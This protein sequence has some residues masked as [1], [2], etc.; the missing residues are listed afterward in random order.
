MIKIIFKK[1]ERLMLWCGI[2]NLNYID[3]KDSKK[4]VKKR[5]KE[6]E[7]KEKKAQIRYTLDTKLTQNVLLISNNER[8]FGPTFCF[9]KLK[10]FSVNKKKESELKNEED[11][12][13]KLKTGCIAKIKKNNAY[14]N[15]KI[16]CNC[17]KHCKIRG[18]C[19]N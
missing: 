3:P 14:C 11:S 13:K 18:H 4:L 16:G 10:T 19:E 7:V 2:K 1:V 5:K 6:K 17:G 9:E 15:K 8:A 12:N